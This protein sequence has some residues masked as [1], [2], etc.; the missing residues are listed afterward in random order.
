MYSVSDEHIQ[1]IQNELQ[2]LRKQIAD[3][4]QNVAESKRRLTRS[5]SELTTAL[6]PVRSA[7][8]GV[9]RKP[10]VVN[11]LQTSRNELNQFESSQA[12]TRQVITQPGHPPAR[13]RQYIKGAFIVAFGEIGHCW[14]AG[15]GKGAVVKAPAFYH[16][17]PGSNPG[18]V[19]ISGLSLMLVLVPAPRDFLRVLRFSSFR[20]NQH[21]KF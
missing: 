19:V 1:R 8:R 2:P 14:G 9:P 15:V 17:G 3:Y 16:C 20:K 6:T 7:F 10:D 4:E 18:P 11:I 13:I 12:T 5:Q 21:S